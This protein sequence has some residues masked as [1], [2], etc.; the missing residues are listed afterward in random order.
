MRPR[1][2][3]T[4]PSGATWTWEAKA[5]DHATPIDA[6]NF[7][8]GSAIEFCQVVTQ[9]RNVADTQ[10]RVE[11]DTAKLWMSLEQCFAG[12][13]RMPPPPGTRFMQS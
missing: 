6:A 7:I 5:F 13:P 10:L 1:V 4:A 12:P 8:E 9:V 2:S 3:L 11:G